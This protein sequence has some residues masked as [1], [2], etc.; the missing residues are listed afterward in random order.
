MTEFFTVLSSTAICVR[1]SDPSHSSA[2][3]PVCGAAPDFFSRAVAQDHCEV[4]TSPDGSGVDHRH[5]T[6]HR[7]E[8]G[9]VKGPANQRVS[10]AAALGTM[11]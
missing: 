5:I 1:N 6:L 2:Y 9:R 8:V 11:L 3:V 10:V 4:G 7:V